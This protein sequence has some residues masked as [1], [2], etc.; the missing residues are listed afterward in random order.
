MKGQC[1]FFEK[2]ILVLPSGTGHTLKIERV[3]SSQELARG[4]MERCEWGAISGMLFDFGAQVRI[5]FWMKSTLLPLD[6]LFMD[7]K[8]RIIFIHEGMEPKSLDIITPP[9]KYRAALELP[10]GDVQKRSI[11]LQTQVKHPIFSP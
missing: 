11:T 4:L 1:A 3:T 5:G 2:A 10:A 8:G 7:E 6:I 9:Q